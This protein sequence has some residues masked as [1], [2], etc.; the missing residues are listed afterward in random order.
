MLRTHDSQRIH[1]LVQPE[2]TRDLALAV[3]AFGI[4][5][6]VQEVVDLDPSGG[7]RSADRTC[8]PPWGHA[9]VGSDRTRRRAIPWGILFDV[10][11]GSARSAR[12]A[13]P[14][15]TPYRSTLRGCRQNDPADDEYDRQCLVSGLRLEI[16]SHLRISVRYRR[17]YRWKRPL[18]LLG[19]SDPDY[20]ARTRRNRAGPRQVTCDCGK[21]GR[22]AG[23]RLG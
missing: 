15:A 19:R 12:C 10:G 3:A 1:L 4:G 9:C 21:Q 2:A 17:G 23:R 11:P 18:S 22:Q 5:P 16:A 14:R 6:V 20:A 7:S 8:S 13:R